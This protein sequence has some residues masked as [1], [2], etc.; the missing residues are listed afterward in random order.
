MKDAKQNTCT[1]TAKKMKLQETADL[2]TFTQ[3]MLNGNFHFSSSDTH[4]R[5]AAKN[6]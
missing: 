2:V 3:E 5:V 1:H 6:N 4:V